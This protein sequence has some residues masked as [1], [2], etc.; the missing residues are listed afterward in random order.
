MEL[1]LALLM[2]FCTVSTALADNELARGWGDSI[3]W[4]TLDKGL[5]TARTED[6]PLMLI[7]HKSW[8]GACKALKPRFADSSEIAELS[9][10]F[11]MVNT[12]DDE[13]PKDKKY[14]PDGGYIPRI[15]FM[16]PNGEIISDVYNESGNAQY[17]YYYPQ[18]DAILSSMRRVAQTR[19]IKEVK[20]EL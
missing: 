7:I 10:K 2:V 6:K 20:K 5:E 3:A 8:C 17:K 12:L 14:A 1:R 9:E 11:I 16:N 19:G 15:F 4:M 13:E 18:P